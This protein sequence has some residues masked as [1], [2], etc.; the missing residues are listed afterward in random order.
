[1]QCHL[2]SKGVCT[3]SHCISVTRLESA[4]LQGLKHDAL[5]MGGNL[6]IEYRTQPA[7]VATSTIKAQIKKEQNKLQR[8]KEAY[9]GGVDT[10]AEYR[11][12]KEAILATIADLE[13]QLNTV[14][15]ATPAPNP[16]AL[17]DK[18]IAAI[19]VLKDP[20]VTPTAKN[21][22]LRCF[23]SKIIYTKSG[24]EIEIYYYM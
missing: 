13:N 16:Q 10:L 17:R 24:E 9:Q 23:I 2:Y 22:L 14:P 8:C 3:V 4:V 5:D 18:I 7:P 12:N 11:N 19:P 15:T 1:M 6:K 21:D 20:N